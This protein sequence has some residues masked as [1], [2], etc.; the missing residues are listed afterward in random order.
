M[1]VSDTESEGG[2][3]DNGDGSPPPPSAAYALAGSKRS[4]I[5]QRKKLPTPSPSVKNGPDTSLPV[6][7]NYNNSTS[8]SLDDSVYSS[9]SNSNDVYARHV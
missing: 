8:S 2:E 4:H 7:D 1:F 5:A 6:P 9:I 3:E